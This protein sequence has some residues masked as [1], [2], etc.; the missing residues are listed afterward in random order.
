MDRQALRAGCGA[1]GR[2]VGPQSAS[3]LGA[4]NAAAAAEN[5]TAAGANI[6]GLPLGSR[7]QH[8]ARGAGTEPHL[9]CDLLAVDRRKAQRSAVLIRATGPSAD[10][11]LVGRLTP[12]R[13]ADPVAGLTA[14]HVLAATDRAVGGKARVAELPIHECRRRASGV[15][16][17]ASRRDPEK[18][19]GTEKKRS[20]RQ[21]CDLASPTLP[22]SR[23]CGGKTP[24]TEFR[25]EGAKARLSCGQGHT[26]CVC[27]T[28]ARLLQ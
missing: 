13:A 24:S 20:W 4:T 17:G 26:T 16:V 7:H 19:E 28:V 5:P 2:P 6:A 15:L 14:N 12:V 1:R 18:R 8:V 21:P 25:R 3:T 23:P 22:G 9:A 11:A 27:T 10:R